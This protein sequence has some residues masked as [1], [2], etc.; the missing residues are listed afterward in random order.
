MEAEKS[1]LGIEQA[2][3]GSR[4]AVPRLADAAGVGNESTRA[5]SHILAVNEGR[6]LEPCLS[7]RKQVGQMGVTDQPVRCR[8]VFEVVSSPCS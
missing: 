3:G 4:V 6:F 2:V 5:Q 8:L 7:F 1:L